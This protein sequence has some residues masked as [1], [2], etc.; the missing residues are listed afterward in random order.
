MI[1]IASVHIYHTDLFNVSTR[2]FDRREASEIEVVM[3]NEISPQESKTYFF[4]LWVQLSSDSQ[5][6]VHNSFPWDPV[7]DITSIWEIKTHMFH[8]NTRQLPL[9]P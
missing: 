8:P 9:I 2:P 6:Q 4:T 3:G 1:F 5:S 7:F